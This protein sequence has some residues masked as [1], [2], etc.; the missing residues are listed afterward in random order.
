MSQVLVSAR[1]VSVVAM[2]TWAAALLGITIFLLI[3]GVIAA[4]WLVIP[5]AENGCGC[6]TGSDDSVSIEQANASTRSLVFVE[7]GGAT[8]WTTDAERADKSRCDALFVP[9]S[10]STSTGAS[11]SPATDN[12]AFTGSGVGGVPR[13]ILRRAAP[14]ITPSATRHANSYVVVMSRGSGAAARDAVLTRHSIILSSA[15]NSLS[16]VHGHSYSHAFHGFSVGNLSR[17]GV[18]RL[19][20]DPDVGSIHE[21]GIVTLPVVHFSTA[22]N[23]CCSTGPAPPPLPPNTQ[24]IG[25]QVTRVGA[26]RSSF[27]VGDGSAVVNADVYILDT[28]LPNHPDITSVISAVTFVPGASSPADG[29][30]HGTHVAGIVAAADNRFGV[31]GCAP[32]ARLHIV[33]VLDASGSGAFSTVV[34]GV[35]YV[36]GQKQANPSVPVVAN[37]SLGASVGTTA[38]NVLDFAVS[39]AISGGVCMLVAAGNSS[40]DAR[41]FSPAHVT[42]AI[43]IGSLGQGN[44]FSSFSNYGPPVV[45]LGPGENVNSTWLGG[46]YK[47]LSGTSMATPAA[48]SVAAAY[49]SENHNATPA[50]V[51]AALISGA[52]A[53]GA[54]SPP[55]TSVPASTGQRCAW[56][57]SL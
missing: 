57:G 32:S 48:A 41:Y 23:D 49:L 29:N 42:T 52:A 53:A 31:V 9:A 28:G 38:Y 20:L 55:V 43:A 34:A 4:L 12:N 3:G 5:I 33:Q 54:L 22:T 51:K 24:T 45:L 6:N 14:F 35:D 2:P 36:L 16:P 15:A 25:W 7:R 30:G 40:G 10:T 50:Q 21:D 46:T 18:E 13:P 44:G 27:D 17:A 47:L 11:A 19:R 37:M 39:Q 1:P 26:P 8:E 56:M